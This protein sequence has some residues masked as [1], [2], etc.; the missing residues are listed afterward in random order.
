MEYICFAMPGAPNWWPGKSQS[1]TL[2]YSLDISSAI[3]PAV[4]IIQTVSAAIAPSGA[5]EVGGS[6]LMVSDDA[7]T[8]TMSAGQPGRI[9]TVSFIVT[10]VDGRIFEF[11]VYQGVP[12]GL[13]GYPVVPPPNPGFGTPLIWVAA[14]GFDF[15][16]PNNSGYIALLGGHG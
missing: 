10:M 8:L 6:N 13:P 4:D 12:P 7:V 5:S 11:F 2:D 9:Y 3:D 14:P 15:R 1:A 16:S